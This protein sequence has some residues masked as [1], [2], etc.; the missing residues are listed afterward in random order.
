MLAFALVKCEFLCTPLSLSLCL[1]VRH[2]GNA[3]NRSHLFGCCSAWN[4][5]FT[6]FI[7]RRIQQTGSGSWRVYGVGTARKT[8]M[9]RNDRPKMWSKF[10]CLHTH[11]VVCLC[12]AHAWTFGVDTLVSMFHATQRQPRRSS[13]AAVFDRFFLF[14]CFYSVFRCTVTI[15][16]RSQPRSPGWMPPMASGCCCCCISVVLCSVIRAL[17]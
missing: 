11:T 1:M 8:W 7:A 6:N 16:A 3:K 14:F 13:I 17:K 10:V 5:S 12:S 15:L 9:L 2:R 4:F